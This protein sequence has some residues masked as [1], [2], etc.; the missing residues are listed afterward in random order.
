[1]PILGG[2]RGTVV[3]LGF[4]GETDGLEKVCSGCGAV[5]VGNRF[6]EFV[7]GGTVEVGT[8]VEDVAYNVS[9]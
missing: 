7:K 2:V 4:A 6:P 3:A 8:E 9:K 5:K 1:V